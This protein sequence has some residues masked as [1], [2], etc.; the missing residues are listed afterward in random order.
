MAGLFDPANAA[1]GSWSSANISYSATSV[2]N[3]VP[4]QYQQPITGIGSVGDATGL[5]FNYYFSQYPYAA[6]TGPLNV[7]FT[8]S[9]GPN[10]DP[11]PSSLSVKETGHA[12]ASYG[13]GLNYLSGAGF[14][15]VSASADD[16]LGDAPVVM[17]DSSSINAP[18]YTYYD[19]QS[20]GTHLNQF[21]GSSGTVTFQRNPS[22]SAFAALVPA[23][24]GGATVSV[25][26]SAYSDNRGVKLARPGAVSEMSDPDGTTHGDTIYSIHNINT[27]EGTDTG[28]RN[29]VGFDSVL[30][31]SWGVRSSWSWSPDS[32]SSNAVYNSV[33]MPFSSLSFVNGVATGQRNGPTE[34]D[35]GYTCTDSNDGASASAK[36][37]LTVHDEWENLQASGYA[38]TTNSSVH[39]STVG[40]QGPSSGASWNVS[41][42]DTVSFSGSLSG[43]FSTEDA[44]SFGLS[45]GGSYSYTVGASLGVN[46]PQIPA[47][48]VSFPTM[49][50][51]W[52]TDS[53]TVTHY[54]PA[55]Y[56]NDY[57]Q[58]IVDPSSVRTTIGWTVPQPYSP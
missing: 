51:W 22:A 26:Y 35:M 11:P 44:A 18:F 10:N 48:D 46:S 47:G 9:P 23:N 28:L 13:L 50:V 43:G 36:Y 32:D 30:S 54:T 41:L 56:D 31:G 25:G 6:I 20:T 53:Y 5:N 17:P 21:D 15:S 58:Y 2:P 3:Y 45:Y 57:V 8:W 16:G 52:Q 14:G 39:T 40:V 37:V 42:S 12:T 34:Y 29:W 24:N 55:G 33:I 7:T 49:T 38:P 27:D 1:G 19:L 4:P